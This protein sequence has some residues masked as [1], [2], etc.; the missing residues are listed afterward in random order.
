MTRKGKITISGALWL[1]QLCFD[2]KT[3]RIVDGDIEITVEGRVTFAHIDVD[4]YESI[5]LALMA[6]YP[7]LTEHG[8]LY[9]DDYGVPECPGATKAVDELFPQREVLANGKALVRF[10]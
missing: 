10:P 9:V 2:S 3:H 5:R 8:V 7:C 1:D 4:L 6:L